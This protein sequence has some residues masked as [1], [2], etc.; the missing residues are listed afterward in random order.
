ML[1][2]WRL[3]GARFQAGLWEK[4]WGGAQSLAKVALMGPM[5][6]VIKHP[7]SDAVA[8]ALGVRELR[9]LRSV[10]FRRSLMSSTYLFGCLT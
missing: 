5:Y 4:S 8:A 3:R 1:L 9:V 7:G 6:I 2:F 10:P